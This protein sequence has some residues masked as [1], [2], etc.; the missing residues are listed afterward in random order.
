MSAN[1]TDPV[2][3]VPVPAASLSTRGRYLILV[4][5][6]LGWLCAGMFMSI[7][8]L[9][10]RPAAIDLLNREGSFDAAR[11]QALNKQQQ[12]KGKSLSP[13]PGLSA[14]D[15]AQLTQWETLV[16]RWFA[17]YQCAFLF[18]AAAGGLVFG[19]LGD[20]VGRSKGMTLSIL[21]YSVMAAAT[22]LAQSPV[23]FLALWFLACM[24]VGGMWPNGV[25]LVSEAW[26][27]LSR[28]VVAGLIGT[29]ANIGIF[30]LATVA[31]LVP[32]TPH[33]WR[34]V[35]LVAAAP[36]LLGLFALVAVA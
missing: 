4:V 27:S 24:G 3:S 21:T 1:T 12:A 29:S 8:Q 34:W 18:G 6:F 16:G 20:R 5:G 2:L 23:Q 19:R 32:I 11:F 7:T 17:W 15:S 35:M 25:A 13:Q 10:G 9:A 28:P 33:A 36:V 14:E 26:S 30:L 22:S 31:S